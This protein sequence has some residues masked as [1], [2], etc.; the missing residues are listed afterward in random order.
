MAV[1]PYT[2][3]LDPPTLKTW[4]RPW[5]HPVYTIKHLVY[6]IGDRITIANSVKLKL[7]YRNVEI[8]QLSGRVDV[9]QQKRFIDVVTSGYNTQATVCALRACNQ[10]ITL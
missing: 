5:P 10:S 6:K 2:K 1:I 8:Q 9:Q 4:L 3:E 7:R